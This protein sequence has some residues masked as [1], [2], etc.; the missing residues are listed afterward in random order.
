MKHNEISKSEKGNL[1]PSGETQCLTY[2]FPKRRGLLRKFVVKGEG[3]RHSGIQMI[4][5]QK[6]TKT[7]VLN[8]LKVESEFLLLK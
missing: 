1:R 5:A 6:C 2:T 7:Q 8:A 3:S 4:T